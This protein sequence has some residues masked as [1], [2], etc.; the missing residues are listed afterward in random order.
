VSESAVRTPGYAIFAWSVL[1]FNVAASA[2]GGFVRATG[3]GA[4][5]GEHW[6]DCN[7]QVVP[8]AP[9]LATVIE[10]T[11]RTTAG[12]ATIL[13]LGLVVWGWRAYPK[14]HPVRAASAA[15]VGF[16]FVEA[17]LGA[18]LVLFGLV[19]DDASPMRAVAMGTHLVSTFFLLA[20]LAVTASFA[21]DRSARASLRGRAGMAWSLGATLGLLVVAGCTGAVAALGDTLF[22]ASSLAQGMHDDL[23]ATAHVFVRLRSLHP[24][25]AGLAAVAA[26]ATASVVNALRESERVARAARGLRVAVLAQVVAGVVNLVLL[27]PVAMQIAHL[28]LADVVWIAVVVLGARAVEGEGAE[29]LP[30]GVGVAAE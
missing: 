27:A 28:V 9:A 3:S 12:L 11:H 30:G 18:G 16:I 8:R 17:L 23:A 29:E 19:K 20:S 26:F 4:G 25:F 13:V 24:L 2:W 22:H 1:A 6:P 7:G 10:F 5:C 15:S 14:G 21:G